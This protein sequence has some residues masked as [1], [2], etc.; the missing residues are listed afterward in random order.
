M[1]ATHPFSKILIIQNAFIGDAILGTGVLEKLH[2]QYPAAEIHYLVRQDAASLFDDHPFITK[3][4]IFNRKNGKW[5]ELFGLAKEIRAYKFDLVVTLQRFG[6]SGFLTWRSKAPVKCGFSKNPFSFCF[7]H[8]VKHS[9]K[10]HL[11]E[12]E[13]NQLRDR[14]RSERDLSRGAESSPRPHGGTQFN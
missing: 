6:S 4:W 2:E 8:E 13:R 3:T 11:H 14:W 5:K 9:I 1:T 10:E 12:T 7:T